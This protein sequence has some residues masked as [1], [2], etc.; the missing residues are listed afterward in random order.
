MR[1]LLF[2]ILLISFSFAEE[3]VIK[4]ALDI[5][6]TIVCPGNHLVLSAEDS[7][8][9]PA[10]NVEL[11]LV[12]HYPYNGLVALGNTDQNGLIEFILTKNGTYRVYINTDEYNHD[13]F[14]EFEY[15]EL[16]PPEATPEFEISVEPDCEKKN[17]VISAYDNGPLKDVII[18]TYN[19]AS[20]T[21]SF[22][23]A[24]LPLEEGFLS[25]NAQLE[26]YKEQNLTVEIDCTPP[27]CTEDSACAMN[28]FCEN[29]TCIDITGECGYAGNHSWVSYECCEALDCGEK[30][31]CENNSCIPEPEPIIN[32]TINETIIE[33]EP[34]PEKEPVCVT[35]VIPFALLIMYYEAANK[36]TL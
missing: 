15:S 17:L 29:E 1:F 12:R 27:D 11:R 13:D 33:P 16:C 14:A 30:M 10:E 22:G 7:A 21:S 34:I 31:L 8:G 24:V 32:E 9:N 20:T 4:R 18:T 6:A 36:K 3:L 2:I 25:I 35:F 28:Q 26:N 23:N 5:S 19:W